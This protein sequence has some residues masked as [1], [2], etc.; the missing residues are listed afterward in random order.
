MFTSQHFAKL[1][2]GD[3]KGE[4]TES[5]PPNPGLTH[6]SRLIDTTFKVRKSDATISTPGHVAYFP[7]RPWHDAILR[8]SELGQSFATSTGRKKGSK[9]RQT[10]D[11][12]TAGF[13]R[14]NSETV[15]T[16]NKDDSEVEVKKAKMEDQRGTVIKAEEISED[17]SIDLAHDS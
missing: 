10:E 11:P 4:A 5:N 14:K 9:S 7:Q 1:K 15:T 3:G 6:K 2:K 17:G 13:K 16:D 12:P 8:R